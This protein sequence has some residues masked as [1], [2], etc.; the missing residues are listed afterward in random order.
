VFQDEMC[1][2]LVVVEQVKFQCSTSTKPEFPEFLPSIKTT[3]KKL[4]AAMNAFF[5]AVVLTSPIH[6]E[7]KKKDAKSNLLLPPEA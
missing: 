5:N 1:L 4:V 6:L 2:G 7:E 3:L